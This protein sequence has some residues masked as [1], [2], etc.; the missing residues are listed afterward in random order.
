M[1][2]T[3]KNEQ[4]K[5]NEPIKIH[6]SCLDKIIVVVAYK[7]DITKEIGED[8]LILNIWDEFFEDDEFYQN[9][10]D[11]VEAIK[12]MKNFTTAKICAVAFAMTAQV[13]RYIEELKK[14]FLKFNAG[15]PSTFEDWSRQAFPNGRY[16]GPFEK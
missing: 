14:D 12:K 9:L 6:T 1:K 4:V 15:E 2:E 5:S 13:P 16:I 7:N 10:T 11:V 3:I 8:T